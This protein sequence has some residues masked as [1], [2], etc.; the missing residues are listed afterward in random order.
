MDIIDHSWPGCYNNTTFVSAVIYNAEEF[1]LN[2][3]SL[4]PVIHPT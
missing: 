4:N 3:K 2:F 1:Q